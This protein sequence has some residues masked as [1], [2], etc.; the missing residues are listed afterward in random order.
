MGGVEYLL[1]LRSE[2]ARKLLTALHKIVFELF[3][4]TFVHRFRL[5]IVEEKRFRAG[6][7]KIQSKNSCNEKWVK[8]FLT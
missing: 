6:N 7:G 3:E 1:A 4:L 8:S 5:E 2:L